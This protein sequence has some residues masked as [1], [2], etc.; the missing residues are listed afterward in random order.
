MSSSF[1]GL[2][3]AGNPGSFTANW[4]PGTQA[5]IPSSFV[6]FP[7]SGQPATPEVGYG[8]DGYGDN[9]YDTPAIPASVA[10]T[11]NWTIVISK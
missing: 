3:P 5:P 2:T 1:G 6:P 10:P 4:G 11:I 9:G 8:E 7:Y